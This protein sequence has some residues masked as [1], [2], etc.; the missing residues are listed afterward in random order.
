MSFVFFIDLSLGRYKFPS[1]LR[2][3]GLEVEVHDVHLPTN[4][5]DERWLELVG[6]NGWIAVT[7]DKRIRYNSLEMRALMEASVCTFLVLGKDKSADEMA[8][9]FLQALKK[10]HK[11]LENNKG[12]FIAKIYADSKTAIWV[13]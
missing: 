9:Q 7:K 5:T 8:K 2:K 3:E 6:R 4:A 1:I 12:P 11:I 13:D 10:I